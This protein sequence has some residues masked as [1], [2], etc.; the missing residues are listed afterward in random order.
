MSDLFEP[1]Q[2]VVTDLYFRNGRLFIGYGD[3]R[4][5]IW[6]LR[7]RVPLEELTGFWEV[8]SVVADDDFLYVGSLRETIE[9]IE[10][11]N[12]TRVKS[13]THDLGVLNL[14]SDGFRLFSCSHDGT[15]K[16]YDLEDFSEEGI[17]V[18]HFERANAC[19][20]H[21]GKLY[22]GDGFMQGGKV[23]VWDLENFKK[24]AELTSVPSKRVVSV[25]GL[26]DYVFAGH[27]SP[28]KLS[29]WDTKSNSLVETF[30]QFSRDVIRIRGN[31][32]YIYAASKKEIAKINPNNLQ[33]EHVYEVEG[34]PLSSLSA[35]LS[36]VFYGSGPN[37]IALTADALEQDFEIIG[38]LEDI[39]EEKIEFDDQETTSRFDI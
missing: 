18:D 16:I 36:H 13:L 5:K 35:S 8:R 1:R 11:T 33:V 39:D 21:K 22:V 3:Y 30:D 29:V 31:G 26:G 9:V 2:D 34:F 23:N 20:S 7:D 19:Y 27:G 15:V 4:V 24:I 38:G 6:D 28:P 32:D 25:Y 12:F 37:V 10:L 14:H 17:L